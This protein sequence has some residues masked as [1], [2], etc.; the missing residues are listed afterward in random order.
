[1]QTRTTP[2]ATSQPWYD[3]RRAEPGIVIIEE[4]YHFEHV[5]SYL[6]EGNDRAL[7]LD[8]GTGAGNM[9]ALVVE[10]TAK[11]V[12]VVNSHA[13]W[14]HIGGNRCFDG[15]LIHEAEADAATIIE[16]VPNA[17]LRRVFAHDLLTGPLPDGFDPATAAFPP[18]RV[19]GTLRDGEII[20]LGGTALEVLHGPG[21]SP[22]G[23]SL[24]HA[25]NGAL[26]STDV[27]Y[28]GTLYVY[29]PDDLPTYLASLRR[30]AD[31][32]PSLTAVYPAHDAS[33]IAP[34]ML[35]RLADGV[36]AVIDGQPPTG[37]EGDVARWDFD[38]F[39]VQVWGMPNEA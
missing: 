8:T 36:R 21:H 10:L 25:A 15:V 31:L 24:L 2:I 22:G 12:M 35:P 27:A 29:S 13:H 14:D 6:I 20:D 17:K 37:Q 23:I 33:P 7:L 30:L 19:V 5:K 9:G 26:F 1:M 3:V 18:T 38:G 32:A 4:P 28:A 34:K 16:G 11:P 39:A